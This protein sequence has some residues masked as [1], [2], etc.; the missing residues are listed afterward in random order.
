MRVLFCT[1]P[2][3]SLFNIKYYAEPKFLPIFENDYFFFSM[4]EAYGNNKEIKKQ[5]YTHLI[6]NEKMYED[7]I[8]KNLSVYM[9][10]GYLYKKMYSKVL[11]ERISSS[12]KTRT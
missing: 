12:I 2:I 5:I 9:Y 10:E 4:Y 3:T 6:N 11:N 8:D 7:F 1:V